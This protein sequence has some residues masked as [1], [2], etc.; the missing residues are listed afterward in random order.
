MQS[1]NNNNK[2]T[3][4]PNNFSKNNAYYYY[5][6]HCL[7]CYHI[8]LCY[9]DSYQKTSPSNMVQVNSLC[10]ISLV[11]QQGYRKPLW[12]CSTHLSILHDLQLMQAPGQRGP[13]LS[14]LQGTAASFGST[15]PRYPFKNKFVRIYISLSFVLANC[16]L[17]SGYNV[18]H[19]YIKCK[20]NGL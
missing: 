19:E 17:Y 14:H 11:F 3:K 7:Q 12:L 10:H 13:S 4:N 8:C 18:A 15:C 6:F 5:K 2:Q 16:F 9:Y 1:V 20:N